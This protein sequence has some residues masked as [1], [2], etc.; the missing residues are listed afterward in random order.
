VK[1]RA[2]SFLLVATGICV[3]S[4]SFADLKKGDKLQTIANLHPD[5]GHRVLFTL[6][7]QL[8]GLIP[9]CSDVRLTK[10]SKKK[11]EFEYSGQLFEIGYEGFTEGA[12]VSFQ[13]AVESI[14]FGK[15]CDKAKIQS[16]SKIDQDGI[17]TGEPIDGRRNFTGRLTAAGAD[18][19]SIESAGEEIEIPFELISRSNLVPELSEVQS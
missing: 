19:V 13:K 12:G 17:R 8:P 16:L 18:A 7:Y 2:W 15:A 5:M 6:N 3:A 11:L 1:S 14:Y 9:V 4:P 10:V